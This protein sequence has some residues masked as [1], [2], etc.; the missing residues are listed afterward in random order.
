ML[1]DKPAMATIAV[2]DMAAAKKFYG[3]T[4]GLKEDR[5]GPDGVMY[6]S[7]D[8][9]IF[10]YPSEFAGTNKA[11]YA[12]W[13]VGEDL[14]KIADDLKGKGVTFEH[15]DNLPGTTLEG[16]VHVMGDLRAVWFKD[17]DGNILNLVNG[18]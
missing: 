1:G 16:D 3:G 4:L 7:G 9:G 12:A 17:P 10:V 5:D 18:M 6:K 8:S 15:Y 13:G 14:D 2:K 11:T